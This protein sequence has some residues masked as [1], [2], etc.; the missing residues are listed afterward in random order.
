MV[1]RLIREGVKRKINYCK[2]FREGGGGA[3]TLRD[4]NFFQIQKFFHDENF[5]GAQT[6]FRDQKFL[7]NKKIFGDQKFF[8][9]QNFFW[10]VDLVSF[11][12]SKIFLG[13][14]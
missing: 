1:N 2:F 12:G 3:E 7:G 9:D 10:G 13:Q 14:K 4:Q 5:F 11:F 6:F 8:G